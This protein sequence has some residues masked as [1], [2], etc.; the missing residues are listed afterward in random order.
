MASLI[1]F[2]CRR[3][4][5]RLPAPIQDRQR[6]Q[7]P[8]RRID[9]PEVPEVRLHLPVQDRRTLAICSV[10]VPG[11][12]QRMQAGDSRLL[13]LCV[14]GDHHSDR[15]YGGVSPEDGRVTALVRTL[16]GVAA[17]IPPSARFRFSN[18][19]DRVMTGVQQEMVVQPFTRALRHAGRHLQEASMLAS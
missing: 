15:T 1:R 17:R 18:S 19:M 3:S 2:A 9:A 7:P 12:R 4:T 11:D 5:R 16:P 8:Q 10:R 6:N 14:T 13:Q